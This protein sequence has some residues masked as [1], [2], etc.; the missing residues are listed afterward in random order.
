MA[1]ECDRHQRKYTIDSSS[2]LCCHPECIKRIIHTL[3]RKS[4][5]LQK[6]YKITESHHS[7]DDLVSYLIERLLIERAEGKPLVINKTWLWF[8]LNRFIRDEMIQIAVEDELQQMT[9]DIEESYS[10][11]Y[12]RKNTITPENIL[13]GKDLMRWVLK[14]YSEPYLLYL[15]GYIG[16]SDLMK[17]TETNYTQL[18]IILKRLKERIEEL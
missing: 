11:W 6:L 8:S 17:L 12:K 3:S 13:I 4:K 1:K 18:N 5:S 16:K 7:S 2:V 14:E 15:S 10:G 9:E